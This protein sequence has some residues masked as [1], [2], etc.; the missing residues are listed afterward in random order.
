MNNQAE[1]VWE[2]WPYQVAATGN[3]DIV[4]EVKVFRTNKAELC[5][6]SGSLQSM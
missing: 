3:D 2:E 1:G 6:V 5:A 4:N